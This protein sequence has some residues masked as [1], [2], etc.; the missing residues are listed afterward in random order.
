MNKQFKQKEEVKPILISFL[1]SILW[2]SDNR[3]HSSC[4][5]FILK[6][7]LAWGQDLLNRINLSANIFFIN[8]STSFTQNLDQLKKW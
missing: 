7:I 8:T 2:L 6:K 4:L 3:K 5:L 1:T